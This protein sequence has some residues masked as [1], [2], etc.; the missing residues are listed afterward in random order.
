M[1]GTVPLGYDAIAKKLI[2]N[3]AEAE[4]V[5]AIFAKASRTKPAWAVRLARQPTMRRANV[6]MTN[7]T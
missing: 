6:S 1:G 4:A 3:P 7:A 2:I 5:R